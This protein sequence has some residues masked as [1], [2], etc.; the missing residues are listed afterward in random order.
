M[1]WKLLSCLAREPFLGTTN[2]VMGMVSP[3][4]YEESQL[5]AQL[6]VQITG[7]RSIQNAQPSIFLTA[8]SIARPLVLWD[9]RPQSLTAICLWPQHLCVFISRQL[10]PGFFFLYID[11]IYQNIYHIE[12]KKINSREVTFKWEKIRHWFR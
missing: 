2:H 7:S 9:G 12:T 4:Y 1:P 5:M 8:Q 6:S 10:L 11:F 3:P